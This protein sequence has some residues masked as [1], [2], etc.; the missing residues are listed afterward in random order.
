VEYLAPH[1]AIWRQMAVAKKY[2][3]FF[4]KLKSPFSDF[5]LTFRSIYA[6]FLGIIPYF[7]SAFVGGSYG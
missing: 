1:G 5:K 4:K 6:Y 7:P 2:F 3:F